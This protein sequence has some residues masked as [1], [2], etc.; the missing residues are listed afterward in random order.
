MAKIKNSADS[1][2]WQECEDRET[3]IPPLLV[4]LK[5]GTTTLEISLGVPQKLN[6]G[7]SYT[8]PGHKYI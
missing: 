2:Y 3:N 6:I 5:P 8:S 1:R 4:V 7:L